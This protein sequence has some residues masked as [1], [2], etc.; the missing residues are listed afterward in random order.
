MGIHKYL[1]YLVLFDN[2]MDWS[3]DLENLEESKLFFFILGL[4]VHS[5]NS[6]LVPK[7]ILSILYGYDWQVMYKENGWNISCGLLVETRN[8]IW[9]DELKILCITKNFIF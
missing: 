3:H 9:Y 5:S 7:L 4:F 1:I 8:F 2:Y 6:Q